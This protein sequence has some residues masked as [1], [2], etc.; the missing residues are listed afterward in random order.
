MS[1]DI[2]QFKTPIILFG[3]GV[4]PKHPVV[5]NKISKAKSILCV[6]GGAD[7]LEKIGHYPDLILGDLDSLIDQ[8]GKYECDVIHLDDQSRTDL[9]KSLEWCF[10]RG[11]KDLSLVGF[12][13]GRD[14]HNVAVLWTLLSYAHRMNLVFYSNYSTVECTKDDASFN[15]FPGQIISIIPTNKNTKITT[16][17]L[18]FPLNN[19]SLNSSGHGISNVAEGDQC[20]IQ[21]TEWVWVFFNFAE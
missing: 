11:I 5:L 15:T 14:D 8:P 7:K 18:K 20:S 6:D 16:Q 10:K 9:E 3:N 2:L 21:S 19:S 13:G 12:S 17:G 4:I 1:P